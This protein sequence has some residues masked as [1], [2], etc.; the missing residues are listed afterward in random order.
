MPNY[1]KHPKMLMPI[2]VNEFVNGMSNGKFCQDKHRGLVS[3]LYH[4]GVRLSEALRSKKEQFFLKKDRIYFDVGPRLK[5]GLHTAPLFIPLRK[6]F[7]FEI[8]NSVEAT[9]KKMRVW[10]YCRKTG[11]NIVDR[12]FSYPHHFRLSKIT[13]LLEKGY[14]LVAVKS[15]TGHK[16]LSALDFYAG[17]VNIEKMG[18]A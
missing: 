8:W 14:P 9:E 17:T 12:C 5:H 16:S 18:E 13:S 2:T 1:S 6:H 3:L 7:A 15:W 4:T 10:P 11:Y